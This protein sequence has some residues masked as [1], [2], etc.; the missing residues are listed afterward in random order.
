MKIKNISRITEKQHKF[1][2]L[3]NIILLSIIISLL[4]YV[5]FKVKNDKEVLS[6]LLPQYTSIYI[7]GSLINFTFISVLSLIPASFFWLR[8]KHFF[9]IVTIFIFL[10]ISFFLKDNAE[11]YNFFYSWI[12]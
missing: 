8:K 11:F 7:N 1:L 2:K 6:P 10:L 9:S 3:I 12:S 4:I 5:I